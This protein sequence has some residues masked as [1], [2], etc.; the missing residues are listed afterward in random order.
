[1]RRGWC[2]NLAIQTSEVSEDFGSF[3]IPSAKSGH[4]RAGS[5]EDAAS[6]TQV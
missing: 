3:G 1:M 6:A 4:F 2:P 5:N